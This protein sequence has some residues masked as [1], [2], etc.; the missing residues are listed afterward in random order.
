[1][2]LNKSLVLVCAADDGYAMPAA[3]TLYS[4]LTHTRFPELARVFVIDDGISDARKRRLER[5]VKSCGANLQWLEAAQEDNGSLPVGLD[6]L[7]ESIYHRLSIPDLL[8]EEFDRAI[9]L[10]ADMIVRDDLAAVWE[11]DMGD[12]YV[13]AC[14]DGWPTV[15]DSALGSCPA[16]A[17]HLDEPYFNSGFMV[18]N[19]DKWR[20]DYIKEKVTNFSKMWPHFIDHDQDGLNAIIIGR[21]AKADRKWNHLIPTW[22]PTHDYDI[23]ENG[24]L[25]FCGP[26]KPWQTRSIYPATDLYD[27]Y[28]KKSQWFTAWEWRLFA[29]RHKTVR[30]MRRVK[31]HLVRLIR[32]SST[33]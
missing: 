19:L 2:E 12:K 7:N 15:G 18:I 14:E 1:M 20:E 5:V 4:A 28:L 8:P 13:V 30:M 6:H 9:Y 22:S 17:D 11:Q 24:T 31:R 25:H 32:A 10:D 21:W 33:E 3:V 29:V 26:F 16:M 23:P 27:E